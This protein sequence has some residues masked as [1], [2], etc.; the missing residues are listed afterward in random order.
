M[1][2]L[3]I[4]KYFIFI[5]M[6]SEVIEGHKSHFH[7]NSNLN[8]RSYGQLF[9]LFFNVH[10]QIYIKLYICW[11]QNHLS[12][13]FI[14]QYID[15]SHGSIAPKK[16]GNRNNIIEYKWLRNIIYYRKV[17]YNPPF[18]ICNSNISPFLNLMT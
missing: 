16:I 4:C 1:L 12:L 14:L 7:I 11:L 5:S 2:S 15:Q 13:K 17:L 3:S 18:L 9:V 6:T 10:W 8:L